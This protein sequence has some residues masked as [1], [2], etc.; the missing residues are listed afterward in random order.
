MR[1]LPELTSHSLT[2]LSVPPVASS[3]AELK[4]AALMPCS[5]AS[6]RMDNRK[7]FSEG[8]GEGEVVLVPECV[9]L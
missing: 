2:T 8:Q 7:P 5:W 9:R 6:W 1:N 4:L 3:S